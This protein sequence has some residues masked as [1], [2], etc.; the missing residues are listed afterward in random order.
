M[1]PQVNDKPLRRAINE[2]RKLQDLNDKDSDVSIDS[3]CSAARLSELIEEEAQ[4]ILKEE[5]QSVLNLMLSG[6]NICAITMVGDKIDEDLLLGQAQTY[7][8]SCKDDD[9]T[10]EDASEWEKVIADYDFIQNMECE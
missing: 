7:L 2:S 6:Y 8:E 1:E 10:I 4:M 3:T 5:D 9:K